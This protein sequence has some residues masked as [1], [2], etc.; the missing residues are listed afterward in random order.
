LTW[1][2]TTRLSD[3]VGR[4]ERGFTYTEL[5]VAMVV[6]GM[7]LGAFATSLYHF[8]IVPALQGDHL[9]AVNELRF[10]LDIIQADGVQAH[11]FTASET[12][13]YG[14]FSW[15]SYDPGLGT[16]VAHTITYSFDGEGGRLIREQSGDSASTSIASH[17]ASAEDVVFTVSEEGDV[18]TFTITVTVDS[19]R[20]QA[21][22]ETATRQV[23]MR[24]GP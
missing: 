13:E 4:T 24:L 3:R 15:D 17:I 6:T 2:A 21:T 11:A 18:V 14:Y 12:P 16:T 20:G 19:G 9:T 5:L 7:V 10:A 1:K 22:T 23:E 8:L